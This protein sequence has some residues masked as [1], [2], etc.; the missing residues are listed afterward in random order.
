MIDTVDVLELEQYKKNNPN[1]N[2][3]YVNYSTGLA[4]LTFNY[5]KP[6]E[7]HVLKHGAYTANGDF[8]F[9][10]SYGTLHKVFKKRPILRNSS[11]G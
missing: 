11:I 4:L 5:L 6:G 10:D 8:M 3:V 9:I 2:K 1:V 7:I